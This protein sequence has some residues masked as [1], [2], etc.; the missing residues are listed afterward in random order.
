[1]V[2]T[3]MQ[4]AYGD[5]PWFPLSPVRRREG[6]PGATGVAEQAKERSGVADL[7]GLVRPTFIDGLYQD[8]DIWDLAIAEKGGINFRHEES[9]DISQETGVR[10]STIWD[11]EPP[12][13]ESTVDWSPIYRPENLLRLRLSKGRIGAR[14]SR[15][16]KRKEA[17]GLVMGEKGSGWELGPKVGG[18]GKPGQVLVYGMV[19]LRARGQ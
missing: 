10:E 5:S 13:S 7:E 17:S 11:M 9:G 1:M 19:W 8:K 6:G 4:K 15:E 2:V 3:S 16:R 14:G 18:R 12:M